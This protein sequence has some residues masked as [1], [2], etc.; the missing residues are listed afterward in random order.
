MSPDVSLLAVLA[1]SDFWGGDGKTWLA[2]VA[3]V[4]LIAL[5]LLA[6]W[7]ARTFVKRI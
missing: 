7:Q 4:V 5:P 3:I 2:I 6:L 1:V